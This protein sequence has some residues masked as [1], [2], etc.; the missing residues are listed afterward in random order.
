MNPFTLVHDES[1]IYCQSQIPGHITHMNSMQSRISKGVLRWF[2]CEYFY[3]WIDRPYFLYHD[4]RHFIKSLDLKGHK[5]NVNEWR[6]VRK[7]IGTGGRRRRFTEKF[8]EEERQE[9]QAYR[10]V[11]REIIKQIQNKNFATDPNNP[12]MLQY[13]KRSPLFNEERVKD[14][15]LMIKEYQIAPLIVGQRV[16]AL[17]PKTKE[18]RTASLLTADV[19]QFH[20]QFDKPE[21]GVI[22]IKDQ[23]VIP[24]SGSD[25]FQQSQRE[26]SNVQLNNLRNMYLQNK[27]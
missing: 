7:T 8:I 13:D 21:L 25:Y 12:Y 23:D 14:V 3:S 15:C 6:L 17:H 1:D 9:L 22:V 5:L 18:L 10:E 27:F 11:F 20:A 26:G 24:I 2:K 19:H 16:L 4:F